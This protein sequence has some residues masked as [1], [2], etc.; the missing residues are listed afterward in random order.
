M[1]QRLRLKLFKK[2]SLAKKYVIN[3][4]LSTETFMNGLEL[5][6]ITLEEQPL[7]NKQK[8]HKPFST[9]ARST[10]SLMKMTSS[11]FS[12]LNAT[13]LSPTDLFSENALSATIQMQ[14]E[15]SVMAVVNSWSQ[16]S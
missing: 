1:E 9:I 14:E 16:L 15:T 12:V 5:T 6:L 7:K 3:T 13:C 10:T 11:S 2:E 8:S 4:L